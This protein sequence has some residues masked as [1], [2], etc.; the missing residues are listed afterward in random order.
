MKVGLP[1]GTP[2]LVRGRLGLVPAERERQPAY[3]LYLDERWRGDPDVRWPHRLLA[4]EDFGAPRDE[5]ELFGAVTELYD[6]ARAGALV[7]VACYGGLGRTGTVLACLAVLSGLTSAEAVPWVR[8]EYH[9]AAIETSAQEQ[10]VA[11]FAATLRRPRD[12]D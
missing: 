6:R 12:G 5:V 10:L 9:D 7:E 3:G 11:R 4:W 1:D 2:L 8:A